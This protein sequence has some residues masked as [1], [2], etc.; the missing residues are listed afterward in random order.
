MKRLIILLV[1]VLLSLS[2][3]AGRS[4]T[5][6]PVYIELHD[7]EGMVPAKEDLE[8]KCWLDHKPEEILDL[9]NSN[10][11][12]PIKDVFLQIQ[13]SGF[14]SWSAGDILHVEIMNTKKQEALMMA[15]E[16]DFDNFQ[17]Y[18]DNHLQKVETEE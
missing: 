8:V 16:L 11:I 9:A 18:F 5:P 14:S 10:L 2:L 7:S 12:F 15:I 17:I 4:A 6:H 3:Y 13:C 1:V